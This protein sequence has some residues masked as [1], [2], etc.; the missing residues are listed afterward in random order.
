MRRSLLALVMCV[1][2]GTAVLQ[3]QRGGGGSHGGAHG[4]VARGPAASRNSGGIGVNGGQGFRRRGN[5]NG[6]GYGW[7]GYYGGYGLDWDLPYWDYVNFPPTD[8]APGPDNEAQGYANNAAPRPVAM[9]RERAPAIPV[10]S[11]QLIEVPLPKDAV[12]KPQPPALF[13]LTNGEK[14]ESRRYVLSADSLQIDVGRRQRTIPISD[15]NVDATIAA[16]QQRGI[17]VA[18]P[19]DRSSL[20]VGF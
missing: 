8:G 5:W 17:D 13:V 7:P 19:Q 4:A 11:P 3:A 15:L 6:Y 18:I 14:L 1:I 9:T 2:F 12:V 10:Q 16:N 20:F